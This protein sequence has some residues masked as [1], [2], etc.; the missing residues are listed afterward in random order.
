MYS[1]FNK[2]KTFFI[3][4]CVFAAALGFPIS[5][6]LSRSFYDGLGLEN[7]ISLQ[8]DTAFFAFLIQ[9]GARA[10]FKKAYI[11]GYSRLVNN[12]EYFIITKSIYVLLPISLFFSLLGYEKYPFLYGVNAILTLSL[13]LFL[14]KREI[15]NAAKISVLLF[16]I[17]LQ[18]SVFLILSEYLG[19]SSG[20]NVLFIDLT[21]ALFY[22]VCILRTRPIKFKSALNLMNLLKV[23][24]SKYIGLQV[25]SLI[26]MLSAYMYAKGILDYVKGNPLLLAAY[27]DAIVISGVTLMLIS[28]VMMLFE[29]NLVQNG[30]VKRYVVFIHMILFFVSVFYSVIYSFFYDF[31]VA[32]FLIVI[33]LLG[34]F[35]HAQTS[36]FIDEKYRYNFTLYTTFFVIAQ[37]V[38]GYYIFTSEITKSREYLLFS[39]SIFSFSI[40]YLVYFI[41]SKKQ[42][43]TSKVLLK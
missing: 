33:G 18:A 9:A 32:F 5:L 17:N 37:F 21:S 41:L 27:S 15:Y 31:G 36:A 4:S 6:I 42:F 14:V 7:I 39:F 3:F 22:M 11:T 28:R 20:K 35:S 12:L 43:V 38:T 16:F 23:V 30:F 26:I 29:K 25:S 8:I 10:G 34:K 24:L 13:G 1:F 19:L 2:W 40:A